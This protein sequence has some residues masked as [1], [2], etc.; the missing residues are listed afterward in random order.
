MHG[1]FAAAAARRKQSFARVGCTVALCV[2]AAGVPSRPAAARIWQVGPNRPLTSPRQA[3][4]VAKDGDRVLFD[5]GV[6]RDCA[7]WR[8]SRLTIEAV[9]PAATINPTVMTGTIVTGPT[10]ADRGLFVFLGND[11][12]VRGMTFQHARSSWHNG[13]GILMEGGNL[14]VEDSRFLD[15]ENGILAGGPSTSVVQIRRDLFQGNGSCE[16]AC[17]HA[18]YAGKRIARLDVSDSIFLDTHV[19]HDIKSRARSTV[20]RDNRIEDGPTGTSSYLIELPDGGD[21]EIVNNVLRKGARSENHEA[22]ISIGTE[23]RLNP[24]L[25]LTI[26]GNRFGSD[27]PELVRFVRNLTQTPARL[28]GN[29]LTGPVIPLDGPGTVE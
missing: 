1:V 19:G 5:P 12:T 28:S 14:T 2:L 4:E 9:A 26:S 23:D 6:Y 25:A 3:A 10:C 24:T 21:G 16:G 17:A 18:V 13:A 11:I 22:A 27:L 29:T 7:I 20:V 15:N 8:A